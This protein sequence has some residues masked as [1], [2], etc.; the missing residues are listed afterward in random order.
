MLSQENLGATVK[1]R[2]DRNEIQGKSTYESRLEIFRH[3]LNLL[4]AR[5]P[6]A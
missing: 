1:G 5:E 2:P 6:V 4:A 3:L